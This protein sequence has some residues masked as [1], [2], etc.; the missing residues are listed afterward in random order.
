M[1]LQVLSTLVS[2]DSGQARICGYGLVTEAVQVRQLLAL[3][4]QY[5][6]VDDELTGAENLIMICRLLGFGRPEARA[7]S[8]PAWL[9][10]HDL[11]NVE[12]LT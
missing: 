12:H 9:A 5:A 6:S 4:G 8:R 10:S 3:T 2:P 1:D 11:R 7:R